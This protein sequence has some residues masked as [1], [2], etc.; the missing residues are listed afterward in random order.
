MYGYDIFHEDLMNGL[1]NAVRD[2]VNAHAYIFEGD[3]GLNVENAARLFAAALTC[4]NPEIAP[5]G[6]CPS[7][8]EAKAGT[9]PDIIFPK[10]DRDRKTIGAQNMRALEGDANIKPFAARRKVYVFTDASILTEQAQNALLKTLEEPPEYAAFIIVTENAD[11]LLETIRSRSVIVR[12]PAVSEREVRKY[13]GEKYPEETDRLDFLAKYCDGV[14]KRADDIIADESFETLRSG[15]LDRLPTLLAHRG[16]GVFELQSYVEENKDDFARIL[17]FW[18]S[19]L[20]DV[21][22]MQTGA[23]GGIINVDKRDA[24]RRICAACDPK[25]TVSM[26]DALTTAR[27]MTARYVSPKA[28][29]YWLAL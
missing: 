22:L 21:L 12:F 10:P 19:F 6:S 11:I 15:A 17:D 13:I 14:P 26:L 2:G 20:R 27:K 18:M 4:A 29:T 8:V 16:A 25:K 28:I 24:L 9:N 1:I 7:C 3:R 5:C 23:D